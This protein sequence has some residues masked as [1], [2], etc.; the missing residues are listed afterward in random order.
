VNAAMKAPER[1]SLGLVVGKFSP[2]HLGHEWLIDQAALH[3]DRLL[4]LSY[5]N[6]DFDRCEAPTRQGWLSIRF[7]GHEIL[8]IDDAGLRR[9][10]AVR[11]LTARG[12]PANDASDETQQQFLGWLLREVLQRSPDAMF[13]SEAYGPA[14]A[15]VLTA[16]LQRE[17]KAVV[18][19]LDRNHAPVSA[20]QI[21]RSPHQ[22]RHWMNP[23]VAAAFVHRIALL[24]A[25]S[26]GKTTLAAALA[27]HF[28]TVWVPEY[29]RELWE[30]QS[31]VLSEAD[32]TKIGH[33]QIRREDAALR[34][35]NRYLFCD[36]SPLTT[37]GYGNWMFGRVSA[38]L[39]LLATRAYHAVVLCRPDFPFVQDGTRREEAFRTQQHAW[40]RQQIANSTSPVLEAAGSVSR[41]VSHVAEWLSQ[42]DFP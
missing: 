27:D 31:G 8:V 1:F 19:D 10:C 35:A 38:Q 16:V 29:G 3:C 18:V 39:A 7:P 13:C 4:I 36:T 17:M 15:E 24:G 2:L 33:E 40:Y 26:S 41:R 37:A 9:A 20:T 23:D 32:L 22:Q 25:E 11:G 14:C 5:A 12:L 34:S 42:L 28:K 30:E 21:R 6:P